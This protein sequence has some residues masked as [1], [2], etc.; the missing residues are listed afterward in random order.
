MF[1]NVGEYYRHLFCWERGNPI[2]FP[3]VKTF[4]GPR[5]C[6][7]RVFYAG[8]CLIPTLSAGLCRQADRW[9]STSVSPFI[10]HGF[11][12]MV[13]QCARRRSFVNEAT[14]TTVSCWGLK[15]PYI[16]ETT[17]E[18]LEKTGLGQS[19]FDLGSVRWAAIRRPQFL[20]DRAGQLRPIPSDTDE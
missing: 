16:A 2:D 19:G 20:R 9:Q 3:K 6:P 18:T 12:R 10:C 1:P 17:G 14:G 4:S 13:Y 5:D 7:R 8:F 11:R 15:T